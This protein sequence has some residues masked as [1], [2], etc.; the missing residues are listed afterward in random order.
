MRLRGCGGAGLAAAAA[1]CVALGPVFAPVARGEEAA[2][3]LSV[4]LGYGL[5]ESFGQEWTLNENGVHIDATAEVGSPLPFGVQERDDGTHRL[6]AL[7]E[8]VRAPT[9]ERCEPTPAA[10]TDV[11]TWL[12][13]PEGMAL[14]PE[15][16]TIPL[17]WWPSEVG[18]F[19]FCAYLDGKASERPVEINPITL[20]SIPPP[21]QL[22]LTVSSDAAAPGR[23]DVG[24][25]GDALVPSRMV[26]SVLPATRGCA[27]GSSWPEGQQAEAVGPFP[28][29]P[30]ETGAFAR[31]YAVEAPSSGEYVACAYLIPADTASSEYYRPY[32]T[33]ERDF[34]L[35]EAQ[36]P[37]AASPLPAT[38]PRPALALTRLLFVAGQL[39][40]VLSERAHVKVTLERFEAGTLHGG[41]CLDR[42]SG[43][44]CTRLLAAGDLTRTL[45]AGKQHIGLPPRLPSGRYYASL[46]AENSSGRS[47]PATLRFSLPR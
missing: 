20:L 21:G 46:E 35:A 23:A 22:A 45:A 2:E 1:A 17:V 9:G 32:E 24:V 19:T 29:G 5:Y 13:S 39:H 12:T 10:L 26:V 30:I 27:W 38:A 42:R 11:S 14:G 18:E 3:N 40:F 7:I 25:R 37:T 34:D 44:R 28:Q 43:R 8:Q 47:E 16:S 36:T 31:T 33:A 15:P 41:R 6:F 4:S